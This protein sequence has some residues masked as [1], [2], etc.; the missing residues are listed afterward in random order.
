M[1]PRAVPRLRS[2][3]RDKHPSLSLSLSLS[4]SMRENAARDEQ[5]RGA[6]EARYLVTRASF[7]TDTVIN[8]N[9]P[10]PVVHPRQTLNRTAVSYALGYALRYALRHAVGTVFSSFAR[11]RGA[12]ALAKCLCWGSRL[13]RRELDR[14]Q[15]GESEAA[16]VGNSRRVGVRP[17]SELYRVISE[18]LTVA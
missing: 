5:A 4:L 7:L 16:C 3:L 2:S 8:G 17:D 9:N 13:G 1:H 15:A 10:L 14:G 18:T 11:W 6:I 12:L